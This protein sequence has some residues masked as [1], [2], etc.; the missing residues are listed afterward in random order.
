MPRLREGAYDAHRWP[1]RCSTPRSA[2]EFAVLVRT[3][4]L[5]VHDSYVQ[6]IDSLLSTTT[7]AV[8][9]L[10]KTPVGDV[11]CKY[12]MLVY[13]KVRIHVSDIVCVCV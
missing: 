8:E 1:G 4:L 13:L 3:L 7:Q 11:L 10:E 6:S 9:V 2:F 12:L 5:Q